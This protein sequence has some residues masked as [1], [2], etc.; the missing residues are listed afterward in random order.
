[1]LSNR[2]RYVLFML[3]SA[4][5]D[6][7]YVTF[8]TPTWNSRHLKG[9]FNAVENNAI[10]IITRASTYIIF[11]VLFGSLFAYLTTD[12]EDDLGTCTLTG[13][14]GGILLGAYTGLQLLFVRLYTPPQTVEVSVSKYDSFTAYCLV[15]ILVTA[16][17]WMLVSVIICYWTQ[18]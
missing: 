6:W 9:I 12:L 10:S 15:Y 11:Y 4:A 13:F 8:L 7:F 5:F 1:M 14:V 16:I 18:A 3:L 2:A 17:R